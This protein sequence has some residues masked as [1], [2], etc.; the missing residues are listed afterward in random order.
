MMFQQMQIGES[1]VIK[2][3]AISYMKGTIKRYYKTL[4]CTHIINSLFSKECDISQA[5]L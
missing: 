1:I 3:Y 5:R 2:M 4:F